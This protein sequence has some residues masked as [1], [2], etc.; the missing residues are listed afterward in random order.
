MAGIGRRA[1]LAMACATGCG[2]GR[3]DVASSAGIEHVRETAD[4][5]LRWQEAGG[6][7]EGPASALDPA[8]H[9]FYEGR[10]HRGHRD[11]SWKFYFE[12]GTSPWMKVTYADGVLDGP[13]RTW[14]RDGS[15]Q[16]EERWT[17]GQ[18]TPPLRWL[19]PGAA[20]LEVGAFDAA[21]LAPIAARVA[22]ARGARRTAR[23]KCRDRSWSARRHRSSSAPATTGCMESCGSETSGAPP[24]ST[25]S[26]GSAS[27]R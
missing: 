20:P 12:D 22:T 9:L 18:P 19:E 3:A 27:I 25:A 13:V 17:K 10:Y 1:L 6:E 15:P 16:I 21:T 26:M 4:G 23:P 24:L 11:G 7:W 8:G 5:T 14:R 2:G